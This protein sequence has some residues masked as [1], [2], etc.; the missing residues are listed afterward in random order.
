MQ[1]LYQWLTSFQRRVGERRERMVAGNH[2]A[3]VART[4]AAKA[5]GMPVMVLRELSKGRDI[6]SVASS[7]ES[8]MGR[9]TD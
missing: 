5:V 6:L 1:W 3:A 2:R 4:V 8:E 9:W 7:K